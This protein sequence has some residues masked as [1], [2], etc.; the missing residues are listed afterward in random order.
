[1]WFELLGVLLWSELNMHVFEDFSSLKARLFVEP[2]VMYC[3][4]V[5]R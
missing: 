4:P 5:G 2:R 1:M 3:K